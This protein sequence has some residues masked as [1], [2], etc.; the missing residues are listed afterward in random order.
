[1][2]SQTSM[3]HGLNRKLRFVIHRLLMIV[4]VLWGAATLSFVVVKFIPGDPVSILTG[5]EGVVDETV[6]AEII[7]QYV[8]D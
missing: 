8:M 3:M 7:H 5:G 6:R 4:A 1:M 2:R